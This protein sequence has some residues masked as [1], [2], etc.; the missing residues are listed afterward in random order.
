MTKAQEVRKRRLE[1]KQ[2]DLTVVAE[3]IFDWIL[4]L[5][6]L[7]T[8]K[9]YLGSTKIC[10]FKGKKKLRA[11]YD[12]EEEYNLAEALLKFDKYEIFEKLKEVI[13]KEE[14]YEVDFSRSAVL[15]DSTGILLEVFVK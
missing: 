4:D 7:D 8:K 9:G 15:W 1:R 11:I 14:G 10:L 5:I 6:D 2:Q 3:G 12:S 13:E